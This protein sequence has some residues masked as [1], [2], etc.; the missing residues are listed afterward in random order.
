MSSLLSLIP[1]V[2]SACCGDSVGMCMVALTCRWAAE[3]WRRVPRGAEQKMSLLEAACKLNHYDIVWSLFY[4]R[5]RAFPAVDLCRSGIRALHSGSPFTF[6]LVMPNV[7]KLPDEGYGDGFA[8]F[9]LTDGRELFLSAPLNLSTWADREALLVLLAEHAG[10]RFDGA[11][12]IHL[13]HTL[14]PRERAADFVFHAWCRKCWRQRARMVLPVR[15]SLAVPRYSLRT[16]QYGWDSS[17][18][19]VC[20]RVPGITRERAELLL[21]N[22]GGSVDGAVA[23]SGVNG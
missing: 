17:V 3:Q 10:E 15:P 11:F 1:D 2:R 20:A 16:D 21:V 8:R 6:D 19:I 13:Q 18:K 23:A 9:C 5:P 14:H 4:P 22:N 7:R 12:F